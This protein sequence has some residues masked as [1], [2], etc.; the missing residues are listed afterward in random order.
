[1]VD[2]RTA[3]KMMDAGVDNYLGDS[4]IYARAGQAAVVTK[5]FLIDPA[6][7]EWDTS[8]SSISKVG[9]RVRLKINRDFLP[10][11]MPGDRI[12]ADP[13]SPHPLLGDAT[14]K[15]GPGRPAVNGRY[16]IFD[17]QKASV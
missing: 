5:G 3:A 1:M 14:W 16:I 4:L 10:A 9:A 2:Y 8:D 15:P 11:A 7:G 6:D 13:A 12:T 17:L